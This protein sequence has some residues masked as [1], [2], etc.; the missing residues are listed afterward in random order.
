MTATDKARSSSNALQGNK[1]INQSHGVKQT[2]IDDKP[3]STGTQM[4]IPKA[5][6]KAQQGV[7]QIWIPKVDKQVEL[8]T[9]SKPLPH[10]KRRTQKTKNPTSRPTSTIMYKWVPKNSLIKQQEI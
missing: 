5:L 6:K 2:K 3:S 7:T 1:K 4:W 10:I 9:K 8:K